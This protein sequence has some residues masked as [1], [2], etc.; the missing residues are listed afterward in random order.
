MESITMRQGKPAYETIALSQSQ[1]GEFQDGSCIQNA[2]K[3][4][5]VYVNALWKIYVP[6]VYSSSL[7]G[8]Y[9]FDNAK[10]NIIYTINDENGKAIASIALEMK[11]LLQ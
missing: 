7:G 3:E 5:V 9:S 8:S 11:P 1:F 4:C 10:K 6:N 2:N